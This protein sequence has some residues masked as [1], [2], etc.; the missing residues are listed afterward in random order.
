MFRL[1]RVPVVK[2]SPEA[3]TQEQEINKQESHDF[4]QKWIERVMTSPSNVIQST[5]EPPRPGLIK[6]QKP[7]AMRDGSSTTTT[8]KT[9]SSSKNDG[10]TTSTS[11]SSL[12]KPKRPKPARKRHRRRRQSLEEQ[13]VFERKLLQKALE[14]E[15]CPPAKMKQQQQQQ[16]QQSKSHYAEDISRDDLDA[17]IVLPT[18]NQFLK[19]LSST[20]IEIPE[21]G[22]V[23]DANCKNHKEIIKPTQLSSST[24]SKVTS[25]P[26]PSLLKKEDNRMLNRERLQGGS[27]SL[28]DLMD[29]DDD[30]DNN[31]GEEE[32]KESEDKSA[33]STDELKPRAR[34]LPNPRI[35]KRPSRTSL[36]LN[37]GLGDI[38]MSRRRDQ[39][40]KPIKPLVRGTSMDS[41][42]QELSYTSTNKINGH[43]DEEDGINK[44]ATFHSSLSSSE[45]IQQTIKSRMQQQQISSNKPILQLR[46]EQDI[47]EKK[48]SNDVRGISLDE[49]LASSSSSGDGDV[50]DRKGRLSPDTVLDFDQSIDDMLNTNSDQCAYNK[51]AIHQQSSPY[52][53]HALFKRGTSLDSVFVPDAIVSMGGNM[54]SARAQLAEKA[55]VDSRQRKIGYTV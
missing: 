1:K 55:R 30:D 20:L 18:R 29:D 16:Q 3:K 9:T 31:D 41:L 42:I 22:Y 2:S 44:V 34:V 21:N 14:K 4:H 40:R 45:I 39:A 28:D 23:N 27:V 24:T 12:P 46:K 38:Y 25:R 17:S 10:T 50:E 52:K 5:S 15:G 8:T 48:W 36:D 32:T 33:I 13:E 37:D 19:K 11:S 26:P 7:V 49:V 43:G 47:K 54:E 53:Q 6:V 51:L 35:K